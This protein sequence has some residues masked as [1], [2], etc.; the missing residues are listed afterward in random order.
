MHTANEE[1]LFNNIYYISVKQPKS[2][3][4]ETWHLAFETQPT[5]FI[6]HV[7]S[8]AVWKLPS[9][10]V[11]R[12]TQDS[13]SPAPS[14]VLCHPPQKGQAS[15]NSHP[16]RF[17][18]LFQAKAAEWSGSILLYSTHLMGQKF[19][20]RCSR[21]WILVPWSPHPSLLVVGGFCASRGKPKRPE[22][23]ASTP[24]PAHK[25]G[26]SFRKN[27]SSSLASELE[28]QQRFCPGGKQAVKADFFEA[29]PKGTDF[30]GWK[31]SMGKF[32]FKDTLKSNGHY[33]V[34]KLR[35][36]W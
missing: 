33:G 31:Q 26:V 6:P 28:Q 17:C 23:N 29:F 2:V 25:A 32:K 5:S 11:K 15:I 3:D 18:A 27:E 1:I 24:R 4:F 9:S 13:L 35:G 8:S 36:G 34:K 20:P 10:W 12:R 19:C 21:P 7:A 30:I 14:Q 22:A 16:P